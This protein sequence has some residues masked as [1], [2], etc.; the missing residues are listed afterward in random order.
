MAIDRKA[1]MYALALPEELP[2]LDGAAPMQDW[3]RRELPESLPH[4]PV[5]AEALLEEAGWFDLD[6]NGFREKAGKELSFTTLVMAEQTGRAA[7]FVQEQVAR[8]G[9]RME[10][11]QNTALFDRLETGDFDAALFLTLSHY[12]SSGASPQMVPY[13]LTAG[14]PVG[15]SN[16]ELDSLLAAA[17][18]TKDPGELAAITREVTVII[19]RDLPMTVL[20]PQAWNWA[21][22]RRVRGLESPH[23][24]DPLR[25]IEHVWVEEA[26]E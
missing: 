4:D 14:G 15:Y 13:L 7:V 8:I 26:S 19:H 2:V 9:A 6:G 10:I 21:V 18:E 17:A 16:T 1:L 11:T 25:F 5:S 3:E 23:R 22:S 20:Y 12:R 24:Y